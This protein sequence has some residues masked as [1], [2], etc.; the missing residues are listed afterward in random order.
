MAKNK[1]YTHTQ[2]KKENLEATME[3]LFDFFQQR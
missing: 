3:N 2:K 1:N